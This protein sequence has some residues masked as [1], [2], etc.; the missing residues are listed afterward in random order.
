MRG[1]T[2][3]RIRACARRKGAEEVSRFSSA[4]FPR[5]H[6]RIRGYGVRM[7]VYG[8]LRVSAGPHPQPTFGVT[9]NECLRPW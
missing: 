7:R 2:V 3:F 5:A 4:P 8:T 9:K 1:W 6:A